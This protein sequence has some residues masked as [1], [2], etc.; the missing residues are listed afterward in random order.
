MVEDACIAEYR[1]ER[2][3]GILCI[4][5]LTDVVSKP[6]Y[7]QNMHEVVDRYHNIIYFSTTIRMTKQYN[8]CCVYL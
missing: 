6:V 7:K 1:Y 4:Y 8:V 2:S 3:S 5:E